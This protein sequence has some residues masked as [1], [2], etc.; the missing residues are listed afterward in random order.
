MLR[1]VIRKALNAF[2]LEINR[3]PTQ[4]HT[5]LPEYHRNIEMLQ[6][7]GRVKLR[8]NE[9]STII[10]VGAAAGSWSQSAYEIW[11]NAEFVMFEPL[12]ERREEL[13]QL[14]TKFKN[15]HF[16]E[17]AAGESAGEVNFNIS[18]DLD[19][20]GIAD[21]TNNV[22][23]TRTVSVRR[24][25]TTVKSLNLKGRYLIKLDTHGFEVPIIE[26][27]SEILKEVD[28]FIIESYGFQIAEKSLLFW[29]MCRYMDAKGF[30]LV[31][32][33]DIMHRP[34]DGAFWQCDAFFAPKKFELFLNN[35]YSS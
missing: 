20:S 8:D 25:D 14:V 17:S 5:L 30:R 1:K 16:V 11:P 12:A 27:A 7:L 23:T 10:D 33:V 31:D 28:L 2:G 18:E 34:G 9:F 24:L 4:I 29:E 22:N 35:S 15:F 3:R 19:G 13:Q 6:G 26:G 32:I 21:G